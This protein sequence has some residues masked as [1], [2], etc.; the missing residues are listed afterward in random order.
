MRKYIGLFIIFS[1][2]LT[3]LIIQLVLPQLNLANEQSN[4]VF[5]EGTKIDI[6]VL[7][8]DDMLYIHTRKLVQAFEGYTSWN[9][10][11]KHI[12]IYLPS[13]KRAVIDVEQSR[14]L[15]HS[16]WNDI[17]LVIENDQTYF[18]VSQLRQLIGKQ[19]EWDEENNNVYMYTLVRSQPSKSIATKIAFHN[20]ELEGDVVNY[21]L[22]GAILSLDVGGKIEDVQ[23]IEETSLEVEETN[24][25]ELKG[26]AWTERKYAIFWDVNDHLVNVVLTVR[27]LSDGNTILFTQG[28]SP[29]DVQ[30]TQKLRFKNEE[31]R[32]RFYLGDIIRYKQ[33]G[34]KQ[35][36]IEANGMEANSQVTLEENQSFSGYLIQSKHDLRLTD[37]HDIRLWEISK[38]KH[39]SIW[40]L[41]PAG[42]HVRA[43]QTYSANGLR[44]PFYYTFPTN[45]PQSMLDAYSQQPHPLFR[46]FLDNAVF[47]LIAQQGQ[48]GFWRASFHTEYFNRTLGLGEGFVDAGRSAVASSYLLK[49]DRLF[50]RSLAYDKAKQFTNY[51]TLHETSNEYYPL[52]Y[53]KIYPDFYSERQK[54]KSPVSLRATLEEIRYLLLLAD[55]ERTD[56]ESRGKFLKD[57]KGM[58]EA[59]QYSEQRWITE[60]GSLYYGINVKGEYFGTTERADV[61]LLLHSI[62][63]LLLKHNLEYPVIASW[64]LYNYR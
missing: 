58:L 14:L 55:S 29:T 31:T 24:L 32:H 59:L 12:E 34:D 56:A 25:E 51:F 49:Y 8:R 62:K 57:A 47:M 23:L 15:M 30:V 41:T 44:K 6:P 16:L 46:T 28:F 26:E 38:Y 2:I 21:V 43:P 33:Q 54:V 48:D 63:S 22:N 4:Q 61:Y 39:K 35:E 13:Q 7:K 17:S 36:F 5:L 40:W 19:V 10:E 37:K 1:I 64:P 18:P 53:Q 60:D 3:I 11:T 42:A 20:L 27:K 9:K 52:G 50:G 45:V